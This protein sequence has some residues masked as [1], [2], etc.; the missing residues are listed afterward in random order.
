MTR[1]SLGRWVRVGVAL[2]LTGLLLWRASPSAVL[3][4]LAR[5]DL[6]WIGAAI[7]LVVVDR[8]LMAYRWMVLLHPIDAA[9]RPPFTALMRL[10]FISTFAGTF[11]P[12]SIGG[13][14]VRAGGLTR[15]NVPTGPAIASVLMDRVLGVFSL[16]LV[17]VAA[18]VWTGQSNLF[19]NA[20]VAIALTAAAT[21]CAVGAVFVFSQ[22][23]ADLALGVGRRLPFA[24][25]R[26]LAVGSAG[27]IRAYDRHHGDLLNVLVG[28]VAV[29]VLRIVQ[30][31]CLGLALG[32]AV[33]PAIYFAFV[34]L[35]LLVMLLP[36]SINGIGTSQVAFVWFFGLVGVPAEQAFALSVLFVALG[37]VGNLP[38]GI[39]LMRRSVQGATRGASGPG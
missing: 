31:Y 9:A 22:R 2:F 21:G 10:F 27:A 1:G 13:D 25:L 30:A 7:L 6:G 11:L 23:G 8:T 29:Q 20:A 14:L 18:L 33:G 15:L 28:S 35:I 17:T 12:A 36:I 26:A 4:V 19:A 5:T 32:L 16:V 34:P 39:L 3:G 37:V 24:R 38:G